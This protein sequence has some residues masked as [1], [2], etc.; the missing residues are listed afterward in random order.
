M[1]GLLLLAGLMLSLVG[2]ASTAD[3]DPSKSSHKERASDSLARTGSMI[4]RKRSERGATDTV[5][6]DKQAL[7]NE[8][9]N[10]NGTNNGV[11][12]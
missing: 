12:R 10:N 5:E 3:T 9:M 7:E 8:R 1:K 11:G 4:P 2:C 6:I